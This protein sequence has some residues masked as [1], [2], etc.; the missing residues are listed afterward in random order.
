MSYYSNFTILL[1]SL[2]FL[3]CAESCT[4]D[5]YSRNISKKLFPSPPDTTNMYYLVNFTSAEIRES[6]INE[7]IYLD[8]GSLRKKGLSMI[9]Q[10]YDDFRFQNLDYVYWK[11]LHSIASDFRGT[12]I[13]S[14]NC[15]GG[16]FSDSDFSFADLRWSDF[17]HSTMTNCLFSRATL[18]RLHINDSKLEGSDFRGANMFGV[19]AHRSNFRNCNFT[20]ALFKESELPDADLT[21]SIAVKVKFIIA[22][23]AGAKLDSADFSYSDFTGAGLE[24]A[25][26]INSRLINVDFR[27]AHLQYADFSGADLQGCN[28]FAA[29]FVNTNFSNAINIPEGLIPL[30]VDG[31]ITGVFA[32]GENDI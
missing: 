22:V 25:T 5:S 21:G 17:N 8:D 7:D 18:F 14:A 26:F 4:R 29:E 24:D 32:I 3:S 20:N 10:D 11:N 31:E 2:A 15:N 16:V 23:M 28:F 12:T 6:A 13:R 30:I 9:P 27:G 1:F 19:E